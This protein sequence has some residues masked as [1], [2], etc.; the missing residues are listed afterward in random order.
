[1]DLMLKIK[2][3]I[4][5]NSV[6]FDINIWIPNCE[7]EEEYQLMNKLIVISLHA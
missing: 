5:I 2:Q 3:D 7:Y 1:M 6:N 4:G